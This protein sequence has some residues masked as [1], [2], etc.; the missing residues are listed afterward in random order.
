MTGV[1]VRVACRVGSKVAR[2]G[3]GVETVN[4]GKYTRD[5]CQLAT[6]G[7]GWERDKFSLAY[8]YIWMARPIDQQPIQPAD[9]KQKQNYY[10][11]AIALCFINVSFLWPK[12]KKKDEG[13][14]MD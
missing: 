14:M 13:W 11:T 5:W 9:R 1:A 2:K 3:V 4:R 10:K 8:L 6:Q 7:I 12:G